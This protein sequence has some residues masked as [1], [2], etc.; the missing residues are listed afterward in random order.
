MAASSAGRN[1]SALG[2]KGN[3]E[4]CVIGLLKS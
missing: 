2:L 1:Y 3:M 4:A